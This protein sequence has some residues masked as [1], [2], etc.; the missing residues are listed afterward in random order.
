MR[1]TNIR[2]SDVVPIEETKI[3]SV[4][5]LVLDREN[6]RLVGYESVRSDE[7]IISQ[8]YKK[9]ELREILQSIAANGYLNIEPLIVLAHEESFTVLEGNR[10]LAAIR[11]FREPELIERIFDQEKLRIN[12]P[13]IETSKIE[14]LQAVSVYRVAQRDDARSFIGFKHINGAAKWDSHAKGKF[15]ADWYR[16]GQVPLEQIAERIG[17][18]HATVKRMV[19]AIYVLEQAENSSIFSIDNRVNP[20]FNF[21][22]LYT[23][24]SR[25]PYIEFL[26]LGDAWS[27]FE[28]KPNPIPSEKEDN[29]RDVLMWL[30]GSKEDD[31]QPV[32]TSQNPDIKHLGEILLNAEGL[33]V[34]RAN[35]N[36]T[37]A[38][39][40]VRP[41]EERF[42]EGLLKARGEIRN[43]ANSLRGFD[44][45]DASLVEIAED[46]E[47]TIQTIVARMRKKVRSFE[48]REE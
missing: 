42:V 13:P 41:A 20:K 22:H 45:R 12:L 27:N 47:E 40:S 7:E 36:L 8:F 28:L 37:E 32:V 34:L 2:P 23:A 35:R 38:Y 14:T 15:A 4:D 10:R 1:R 17:D 18:Q 6:P 33:N 46:I 30:Y 29:L 16:N 3:V 44:G 43:V 48:E 21:S 5:W 25:A 39:A 9:E 31:L 26:G 11:L 19:H 24:L